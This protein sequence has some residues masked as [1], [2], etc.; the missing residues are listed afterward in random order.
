MIAQLIGTKFSQKVFS[1]TEVVLVMFSNSDV[2][3]Y[4]LFKE[5]TGWIYE[6]DGL[7]RL[8]SS[9]AVTPLQAD[10]CVLR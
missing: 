9:S 1:P 5:M 8:L 4:V 10:C 2:L 6:H 3:P 7:G